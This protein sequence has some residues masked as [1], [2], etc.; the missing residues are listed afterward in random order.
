M[1]R[2]FKGLVFLQYDFSKPELTDKIYKSIISLLD[3]NKFFAGSRVRL[4]VF[5]KGEG[6]YT[7]ETNEPEFIIEAYELES[8][9]FT[10]NKKGL[11]IDVFRDVKLSQSP[12]SMF[13]SLNLYPYI[14]AGIYKQ[15]KQLDDCL[16]INNINNITEAISSNLFIVKDNLII[17][18]SLE[19]GG[20]HGIM[21]DIIINIALAKKYIVVDD[22]EIKEIDI[23]NANEI[24][25]TN[26][27]SGIRWVVAYK[28]KRFFNKT[29]KLFIQELNSIIS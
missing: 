28:N 24:F 17:S 9:Y 19:Y 25:L 14:L 26:S 6:L 10:L 23:I 3:A 18:P 27:V 11:K 5:R 20:I 15:K 16:L 12:V 8:N 2:L 1:D 4:S 21:R 7:P 29:S 13:K 22:A